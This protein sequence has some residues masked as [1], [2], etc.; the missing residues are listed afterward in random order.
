VGSPTPPRLISRPPQ[1][2]EDRLRIIN[3]LSV[4]AQK[5]ADE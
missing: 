3:N 4:A 5:T 1:D 2:I